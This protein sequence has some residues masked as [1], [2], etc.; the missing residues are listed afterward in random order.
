MF[1]VIR[2]TI[3]VV[4]LT[5]VRSILFLS[6]CLKLKLMPRISVCTGD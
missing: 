5:V 1:C 6:R 2:R 4:F 3:P